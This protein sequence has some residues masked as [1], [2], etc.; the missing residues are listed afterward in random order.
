MAQKQQAA[1]D[2]KKVV[3]DGLNVTRKNLLDLSGRNRLLN[4]KHTGAKIL[5]FV[6]ELPNHI[7][8]ELVASA[9]SEQK[10]G[11]LI[12]PVPLP[13]KSEYPDLPDIKDLKK[14]DVKA[15]ART[16]G[17][18][19]E[20]ELAAA[21]VAT[22]DRHQDDKLQTLHF[23]EDLDRIVRRIQ[24]E[25]RT[26]IEESGVNM[27]FLCLGYLK[28]S[29]HDDS[30]AFNYAPLIMI[31]IEIERD[32]VDARTGFAK[33]RL[34]Y[35]G[36]DILDN[37]CLREKLN[38]L[39]I[40]L[41]SFDEFDNPEDYFSA[42]AK[43]LADIKPD[44]AIHRF[45]T[46]GF[47]SFGKMLMYLD[48]DPAKWPGEEGIADAA[49]ILDIF[50]GN[51]SGGD[52]IASEFDID[53][54]KK[55]K[56]IA[57][58]MDADSSQHS[59]IIDVLNGK[60][61]VIEGPPG[62]GKSQTITNL[63]AACLEQGKT[64][65]F[66]AEKLAALQVVRKRLDGVGL[67]DFC[68]ELHSHKTQKKVIMAELKKRLE[69][70]TDA[71]RSA[72]NLAETR[73]QELNQKKARLIE[74][75]KAINTPFG[76]TEQ[77]PHQIFWK[78]EVLQ[79]ELTQ[80][81][82][83]ENYVTIRD[84]AKLT[85]VE[86]R[87]HIDSIQNLA[88]NLRDYFDGDQQRKNHYW[89]G[90]NLSGSIEYG[91][92]Q[93]IFSALQTLNSAAKTAL[94]AAGQLQTYGLDHNSL[95]SYKVERL[96]EAD[97]AHAP[98]FQWLDI[99]EAQ[100]AVDG[101]LKSLESYQQHLENYITGLGKYELTAEQLE[102]LDTQAIKGTKLPL[103]SSFAE[104]RTMCSTLNSAVAA[105]SKT[106]PLF[107]E[108]A[109]YLN[110]SEEL[111]LI[112]ALRAITKIAALC[113]GIDKD[114]LTL[115]NAVIENAMANAV[116]KEL[117]GKVTALRQK[118]DE[119]G[120]AFNLDAI[121]SRERLVEI[122][123]A[124][125]SKKLLRSF[126]SPWRAA[127]AD[128]RKLAKNDPAKDCKAAAAK[129]DT[130][131]AY[132]KEMDSFSQSAAYVTLLPG[133]FNGIDTD[134]DSLQIAITFYE[135]LRSELLPI[136]TYGTRL[137]NCLRS[138]EPH[139]YEWFSQNH[140]SLVAGM[141]GLEAAVTIFGLVEEDMEDAYVKLIAE[142][143]K[144]FAEEY[145]KLE[146]QLNAAAIASTLSLAQ[147]NDALDEAKATIATRAQFVADKT[148]QTFQFTEKREKLTEQLEI[149]RSLSSTIGKVNKIFPA[150]AA[151]HIL[152]AD[153]FNTLQVV[154]E[155][156]GHMRDYQEAHKSV[157]NAVPQAKGLGEFWNYG[158]NDDMA[159]LN[160]IIA[161]L[162]TLD[163]ERAAFDKWCEVLNGYAEVKG[164]GLDG[165]ITSFANSS[166]MQ[167]P[168]SEYVRLYHFLVYH[169]LSNEVL[170]QNK[171]L[172][173]FA[174]V[175]HENVRASFKQIDLEL[176]KLNARKLAHGISRRQIPEGSGGR[177]PKEFTDA[178][179]I[180]HEIGK[181]K[182]HIPI[183]QLVNR[184]YDALVAMKPCFMM[185]PL[186][187]A[188]YIPPHHEKFDILIMDEASQVKPEDAI[189]VLAR[190]K[191]VVVVGDSNQ[192]PP[193]GFFD[194]LGGDS[195]SEDE[196]TIENSESILDVCKPLFQ[197]IRRLRW[198]YRSQHQSLI[199]FSN[200]HF[201]DNDLIIFPSPT[202]HSDTAGVR[203]VYVPD[204]IYT[205]QSNPIEA[206]RV[207][208][209]IMRMIE[210][211]P[212]LSY[213][214]VTLNA[215]QKMVI[216]DE[217]ERV[218][219]DNP[220]FDAYVGESELTDE[221]FFVKNLETVQGDERDVI[222]IST[223]FGLDEEGTFRQNFGP[224]NG[225]DG[226]RRL[227]VLFTRA[228]QHVRIFSSF[229]P[230]RI[231]VDDTKEQRGLRALKDYLNYAITGVDN[232]S[233]LTG[234]EPDSDFERA[235]GA[236]LK[237]KGYDVVYQ[238]GVAGYR[239]DMVVRHPECPTDY[240]I[241]IECDG[242]TYH[243]ARSAR[244]RDRL[245]EDNLRKLGWSHIHRI[246]STDWF[247][248]REQEEARLLQ[249]VE[250]AVSAKTLAA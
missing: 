81:Y 170:R 232:H 59:A 246:W 6:D 221:E 14:I 54:D 209:E 237:N 206:K 192:L 75:S 23:P 21:T 191:Q 55:I 201:Y 87:T 45:V 168:F 236:Y 28:W 96:E 243:S 193:T 61:L 5:R 190:A 44:W 171:V 95:K 113:S 169:A 219:K 7:Y 117:P 60:N 116:I 53:D 244:D 247:K 143:T 178:R 94:A 34:K 124:L 18:N 106:Q 235:V 142:R 175:T 202:A 27:L 173:S 166:Q 238:L 205:S 161:K 204:G 226:W 42:L 50:A 111:E 215:K 196:T 148:T 41:P 9:D 147:L 16:L 248:R 58:V 203:H 22:E 65:L 174:R 112:P 186:S 31:P 207:V 197:P 119:L 165:M 194:T 89:H 115:R 84:V 24:S 210:Q 64:V 29:D 135:K 150:A 156:L 37:I 129:T 155:L 126:S 212:D 208:E 118:R 38:Q 70:N 214:I 189:G 2:S 242:A 100:S 216:E 108:A 195:D 172:G 227:N 200:S 85:L 180:R 73:L 98:Y 229:Q 51:H 139:L 62:T 91:Q 181:Q 154:L 68:L 4:F 222:F 177:S 104:I 52:T 46:I 225:K 109:G 1:V 131:I 80:P 163:A 188:Q 69:L 151:P 230:E 167:I 25:A 86:M 83:P 12:S 136:P 137:Y 76:N 17:I 141:Q 57:Q 234:Q 240:V 63:I 8:A 93:D 218:R 145:K 157:S 40:E 213:G 153:G 239:I 90:L 146:P 140:D 82:K 198:H 249:A 231:K 56:H 152:C 162:E 158:G 132:L 19:T 130:L 33:F 217:I 101:C 78:T 250:S 184:A 35:T 176:Q 43:K 233:Y 20:F 30:K 47:L 228:K 122:L 121:P 92:Q 211:R 224:I 138:L 71:Y 39:A 88:D 49:H 67:G 185:G 241:A 160:A 103:R 182:A 3:T 11:L 144:E 97:F 159:R 164:L 125:Q 36:E 26:A 15:H 48:L 107:K 220:V 77:T 199:S 79:K 105:F 123:T 66:V 149:L 187:V 102:K 133:I 13:K 110:I 179:L 223:T 134:I 128:Y 127:R 99:P 245:R 72:T 74:Y 120:L 183:R 114:H 10:K 32:K